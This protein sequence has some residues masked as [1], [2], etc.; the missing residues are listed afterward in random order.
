MSW[1]ITRLLGVPP[2]IELSIV[3]KLEE[4]SVVE[5]NRARSLIR[6]ELVRSTD[7]IDPPYVPTLR[8]VAAGRNDRFTSPTF[9]VTQTLFPAGTWVRRQRPTS[10]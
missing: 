2:T 7:P 1:S 9:A 3:M 5:R 8:S 10:R 4:R 6:D